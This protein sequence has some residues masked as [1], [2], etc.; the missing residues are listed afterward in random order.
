MSTALA[1]AGVT[2]ILRDMLNNAMV[3]AD[4]SGVVGGNVNIRTMPPDLIEEEVTAG[5]SL[6]NLFLHRVTP[7]TGWTNAV[8]PVRD[9]NGARVA[10]PL[11]ALDLHYLLSAY[12]GADLHAEILLGHAM[13]VLNAHAVI[14]RGEIRLALDALPAIGGDLPPALQSL[15][16]TGL[17]DQLEQ[18]RIVPVYFSLDEQSK[19]WTACQASLRASAAYLVT[20]VLI[21]ARGP[22][23]RPLPVLTLGAGNSGPDVEPN[24][25]PPLPAIQGVILPAGQPS[26]QAGS[27]ITVRGHHLDGNPVVA[28]FSNPRLAAPI[29]VNVPQA[30]VTAT[31]VTLTIPNAPAAWGA[32]PFTIELNVLP[33]G[34]VNPRRTNGFGVQ[35]APTMTLPPATIA[36]N[37]DDSVSVDLAVAPVVRPGQ[38]VSLAIGSREAMAD[39]IAA[40]TQNLGFLFP[41]LPAGNQPARLRVDG[42][43]SW[44]IDRSVRPPVF[45][46]A[47]FITVPA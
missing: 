15:A 13:Q 26:A 25:L 17:A 3:D 39:P 23:R 9:A 29:L 33:A 11:L 16:D 36:R 19:L 43:D 38:I 18:M 12:G 27:A 35:I 21:E 24:L 47:Q 34:E 31:A 41:E 42:V 30:G 2:Q 22:A 32:G 40:P 5:D 14:T 7:N 46:P 10:N 20:V 37:A 44:L 8:L 45:D 28:R 6:L 4:V 1:I